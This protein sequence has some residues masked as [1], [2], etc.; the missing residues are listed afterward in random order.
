MV[1][2]RSSSFSVDIIATAPSDNIFVNKSGDGV[3]GLPLCRHKW[4]K[5]EKNSIFWQMVEKWG[6]NGRPDSPDCSSFLSK[7]YIETVPIDNILVNGSGGGVKGSP[8][9]RLKW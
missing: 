9:S 3:K 6:G 4:G 7:Y 8:M 2:A 1:I 5:M